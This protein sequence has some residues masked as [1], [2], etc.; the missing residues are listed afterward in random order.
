MVHPEVNRFNPMEKIA[1]YKV[2]TMSC[3]KK[4]RQYQSE[5][6]S[7]TEIVDLSGIKYG[8]NK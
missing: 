4:A 1:D 6:M 3:E 2:Q 5:T 7:G 8:H